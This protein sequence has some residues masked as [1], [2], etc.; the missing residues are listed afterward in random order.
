MLNLSD[1]WPNV[2]SLEQKCALAVKSSIC[3]DL[4]TADTFD[5][6]ELL[7]IKRDFKIV[8]IITSYENDLKNLESIWDDYTYNQWLVSI[9][10]RLSSADY[11][12][13]QQSVALDCLQTEPAVIFTPGRSGTHVL[14]HVTGVSDFL[15]H[16]DHIL[17]HD[18]FLRIINAEKVLSIVRK[19][20]VDQVVSDA[21]GKKYGN[22]ITTADT[23]ES[24]QQYFANCEPLTISE[25]DY[26]STLEK[27]YNYADLLLGIKIF[28]NKQI[29]F[30]LLEDL[31]EHFDAIALVKNPYQ[32]ENII[33]NYSEVVGTC[34]QEYQHIYD[35]LIAKLQCI[36]GINLH[37]HV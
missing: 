32:V 8:K 36:F 7:K 26:R 35:Q 30:S 19:N 37:N 12:L 14:R 31:H 11:V 21:I 6:K 23:F 33:L 22:L 9:F 18:Q 3:T 15:H 4:T 1:P 17:L 29:E 13:F 20:F 27:L 2:D 10:T 24:N 34:N 25:L 16:N 28:Y 5:L